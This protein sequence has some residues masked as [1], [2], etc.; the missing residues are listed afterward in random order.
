MS[1]GL[2]LQVIGLILIIEGIIPFAMP[3][4]WK[5]S[6]EKILSK[7]DNLVRIMGLF[8]LVIGIVLVYFSHHY[9]GWS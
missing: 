7:P 5:N 6:M 2:M 3:G 1:F 9:L 8:M 4:Y